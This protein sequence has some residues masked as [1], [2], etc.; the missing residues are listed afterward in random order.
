MTSLIYALA[1]ARTRGAVAILRLSGAG[2]VKF[3]QPFVGKLGIPARSLRK[4]RDKG[5]VIDE[6]LVLTFSAG[7]SFTGEEVVELHCHGSLAVM[8]AILAVF[9]AAPQT[10]LAAPGEF[11]KKAL[12]NGRLDLTQVEGLADLIQAETREQLVL[13]NRV[14][15]GGFA[16]KVGTWR[17]DLIRACALL[18]ASIDFSDED[19]PQ[20]M[21]AEVI[22]LIE[23]T[24][25]SISDEIQGTQVAERIR[26]GFEVAIIGPP[27]SGKSTLLNALA[28]RQIA[29]TSPTAG[30]TRDI[31]ELRLDIKGLPVTMLDTAG[32]RKTKDSVESLGVEWAR[33]RASAADLRLFLLDENGLA[34]FDLTPKDGDI[35]LRGKADEVPDYKGPAVSGKT[36]QGIDF[37]IEKIHQ[38]L[39][40]R[41]LNTQTATRERHK[42][43]MQAAQGFLQQAVANLN[44][45]TPQNELIATELRSALN[46]FGHMIGAVGVEDLL[47]EIFASFCLGK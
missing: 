15:G 45:D 24:C 18:E 40:P 10:R 27:N 39:S 32:L 34:D 3:V 19:I 38:T 20:D 9:G 25:K 30:T 22:D 8:D 16:E 13:A 44:S 4:F 23:K 17:A 47:D 1:S 41:I 28:G 7:A 21:S 46:S 14:L 5:E 31:I 42:I 29:L 35:V 6:V 11:T 33:N 12:E 26:N 2:A 43:A 36:G 37:I